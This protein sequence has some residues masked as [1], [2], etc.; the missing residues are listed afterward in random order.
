MSRVSVPGNEG[1]CLAQAQVQAETLVAFCGPHFKPKVGNVNTGQIQYICP[2]T[3]LK[4]WVSSQKGKV[5]G[6]DVTRNTSRVLIAHFI[7][8][9]VLIET[10]KLQFS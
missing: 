9:E 5:G 1:A 4:T 3:K 8:L 6:S 7:C 2:Q 10:R